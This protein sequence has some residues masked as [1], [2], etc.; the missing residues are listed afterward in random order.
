[1]MAV[2]LF[3]ALTGSSATLQSTFT[4]EELAQYRLSQP[5]FRQFEH[6]SRLIVSAISDHPK[7]ND[8][9]L[10][11]REVLLEGDAPIV[12]A[13]LATRLSSEPSFAAAL[14]EA[15]IS[16]REYARFALAL[17]AARLAHG[18]VSSGAMRRVPPGPATDNVSFIDAHLAEV[19]AL[20]KLLGVES[21]YI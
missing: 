1:M 11:T 20:L 10:F 16:A 4:V 14:R 15:G 13:E 8:R 17:F 6:A 12:A 9:P 2:L 19:T 7:L 5:V 21:P 18:F 3:I